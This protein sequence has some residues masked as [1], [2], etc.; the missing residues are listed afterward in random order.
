MKII[1]II[2]LL[3]MQKASKPCG[4]I[5]IFSQELIL[6]Q[7]GFIL[8]K[9]DFQTK[10]NGNEFSIFGWINISNEK[11][12]N[13][14]LIRLNFI[15]EINNDEN[16]KEFFLLNYKD[17]KEEILEI[18]IFSDNKKISEKEKIS[19][20]KNIWL[21]YLVS[22]NYKINKFLVSIKGKNGSEKFEFEKNFFVN[23]D[24]FEIGERVDIDIGCFTDDSKSIEE[25]LPNCLIGK[26][27]NFTY[28]FGFL[29]NSDLVKLIYNEN[30]SE[31]F[32]FDFYDENERFLEAKND[33]KLKM[34]IFGEKN[35]LAKNDFFIFFKENNFG[36]IENK[37][38]FD[39]SKFIDSP[40]FYFV[41]EFSE[42]LKNNFNLLTQKNL[43]NKNQIEINLIKKE[44]NR[45]LEVSLSGIKTIYTSSQILKEKKVYKII[46]SI[47]RDQQDLYIYYKNGDFSEFSEKI[48][49]PNLENGNLTILKNNENSG[50]IDNSENLKKENFFIF[51]QFNIL[52]SISGVLYNEIKKKGDLECEKNCL[53]FSN[54]ENGN[55]TCLECND[56]S[57]LEIS[58]KNSKC[59]NFCPFEFK[60]VENRCFSCFEKNCKEISE[61]INDFFIFEQIGQEKFRLVKKGNFEN[62][63]EFGDNFDVVIKD[64]KIKEDFDYKITNFKNNNTAIYDFD[65]KKNNLENSEISIIPK[66]TS[67]MYNTEKNLYQKVLNSKIERK[68]PE[69]KLESPLPLMTPISKDSEKIGNSEKEFYRNSSIEKNF[70]NLGKVAFYLTIIGLAIGLIGVFF[71]CPYILTDHNNFYLQKFIQSFLMAQYIAFWILYK[72][73]LPYNLRNFLYGF[74]ELFISWHKVFKNRTKDDFGGR[75]V[76]DE[77][78]FYEEKEKFYEAEIYNN[79]VTN[80]SFILLVQLFVLFVYLVFKLIS[81]LKKKNKENLENDENLERKTKKNWISRILSIFEWKIIIT[82]FLLFIIESTIFIIYSFFQNK[83]NHSFFIFNLIFSIIYLLLTM[84]LLIKVFL[85]PMKYIKNDIF[86]LGEKISNFEFIWAGLKIGTLSKFFQGIQYFFYLLFSLFIFLD[87]LYAQIIVNLVLLFIF[88]LYIFIVLPPL[89]KFWKIEQIFIHLL[90]LVAKIFLSVLIFDENSGKMSIKAK[91]IIG[92]ILGILLFVILLWNFIILILKLILRLIACHKEKN[93]NLG[94]DKI[95]NDDE[96]NIFKGNLK[97]K[98]K[99]TKIANFEKDTK[100]ANF[101]K[102]EDISFVQTVQPDDDDGETFDQFMKG[103]LNNKTNL[104]K[105]DLE[106]KKM[107]F[108]NLSNKNSELRNDILSEFEINNKI[109]PA[110]FTNDRGLINSFNLQGNEKIDEL[111]GNNNFS[112]DKKNR[113]NFKGNNHSKKLEDLFSNGNTLEKN[114]RN[115]EENFVNK[116]LNKNFSKKDTLS[117]GTNNKHIIN[118]LLDKNKSDIIPNK[119]ELAKKI[120]SDKIQMGIKDDLEE[121]VKDIGKNLWG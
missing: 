83:F 76:F 105:N 35:F 115:F 12:T 21:F 13:H 24:N 114:N 79:F 32:L 112:V 121:R 113:E 119:E 41:F 117:F 86:P 87:N 100:I 110:D 106:Y 7:T 59:S 49:S 52:E 60:N 9:E 26:T 90:L 40:T 27:R 31:D 62:S 69:K 50:N 91:W 20:P 107:K 54:Y 88:C 84:F 63:Q 111:F 103:N 96:V 30:F 104:R 46:I 16:L 72:I 11:K 89:E 95:Q 66:K 73:D 67:Q 36:I 71:K 101:E 17:E 25:N 55:E 75:K 56:N 29:E 10:K 78:Y 64:K 48:I 53:L 97:D 51:Y 4:F 14:P 22:F 38:L 108:E 85:I 45:F 18:E 39:F 77:N 80:F 58:G 81:I 47:I 98:K 93:K 37:N 15:S 42:N 57:V 61:N 102:D 2:S 34:E 99:D 19:L 65:F 44:N 5:N 3:I 28:F 92:L 6:D 74:Y 82:L 109:N 8:A 23:S 1:L 94:D 68:T 116:N 33:R 43:E 118:T 120:I 70:K